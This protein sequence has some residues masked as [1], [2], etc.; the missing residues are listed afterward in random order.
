MVPH[1]SSPRMS[2][3]WIGVQDTPM[4]EDDTED[5]D[6]RG[7]R[8]FFYAGLERLSD[9]EYGFEFCSSSRSLDSK[10]I[11]SLHVYVRPYEHL[12]SLNFFN[13]VSST[14]CY[15]VP[16]NPLWKWEDSTNL[17]VPFPHRY[18]GEFLLICILH[19]PIG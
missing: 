10:H 11:V 8:S 1:T 15:C 9:E 18:V 12:F 13:L 16:S 6:P 19:L 4:Q 5:D 2:F 3:V 7:R 14:A 17:P